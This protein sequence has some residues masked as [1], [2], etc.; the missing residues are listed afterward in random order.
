MRH[1][2]L[3]GS[4]ATGTRRMGYPT[5][6]A[7]LVAPSGGALGVMSGLLRTAV[8]TVDLTAVAVTADEDLSA[9][10]NA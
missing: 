8:A 4:P 7:G 6:T 5:A 9:A 1:V 3:L 10:A 2:L